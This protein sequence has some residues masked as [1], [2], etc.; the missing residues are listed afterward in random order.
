MRLRRLW[1]KDFRCYEAAD[2][3]LPDGCTVV[4]GANGQGK[5]SLLEA[6]GWAATARSFR[7]VQD[8]ALVRS[9]CDEAIVR[10][11][12]AHDERTVLVE[13]AIRAVGR[14]RVLV[15]KQALSKRS[16]LGEALRVTVFAPDD[17]ELVKG[18][19]AERR[20]YLDELLETCIPSFTAARSEYERVL[21][22]RNARLRLGVRDPE[23]RTTLDVLDDRLVA[24]GAAVIASRLELLTRLGPAVELAYAGLAGSAPGFASR[25]RPGW[26]DDECDP[27]RL[28]EQLRAAIDRLRCREL[29]RGLTLVGPHRD[30]WLLLLH[31]LETRHHASQGEQR[32][33][34]LALRLAAH[35]VVAD[36]FDAEPLLLLDDVF[37]ELDPERCAA[38]VK[39]LPDTQTV[40]TTANVIPSG[41]DVS[42]RLRVTGA[43]IASDD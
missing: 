43:V 17:L 42:R 35:R 9:G 36:A 41:V 28:E 33:L 21:K 29:D 32:T 12:I 31:D 5:T 7:G 10:A 34:A 23:E 3:E 37:S 14:N 13:A 4:T 22:Q 20:A 1:L 6:I 16:G 19:P 38:L 25:Y 15:N 27:H 26:S 24:T 40:L 8:A 39:C 2:L 11:E 18:G 30:D